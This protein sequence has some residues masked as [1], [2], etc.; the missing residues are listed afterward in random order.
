MPQWPRMV[1]RRCKRSS[2]YPLLRTSGIQKCQKRPIY[3]AKE[4]YLYGK[5]GLFIWQK[6]PIAM[7]IPQVCGSQEASC[8]VYTGLFCHMYR[9]LLTLAH[10]LGVHALHTHR[11][12]CVVCMHVLH[13]HASSLSLLV[14]YT[15]IASPP[16]LSPSHTHT[17]THTHIHTPNLP[18]P[19]SFLFV[20][21]PLFFF[22]SVFFIFLFFLYVFPSHLL[23]S[24]QRK[25]G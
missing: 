12:V 16:F 6:R 5:R 20:S 11:C 8:A 3:M 24:V 2:A 9:S 25:Q 1:A 7:S 22:F 18:P 15:H 21:S 4:T 23:V 13:T 17:H 14:F 10:T 19:S